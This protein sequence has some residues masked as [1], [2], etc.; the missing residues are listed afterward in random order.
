M[1]KPIACSGVV[2]PFELHSHLGHPSLPLLKKLYLQFSSL[3][4]LNCELCQ[5]AKLHR[6]HLSP[7][8]YKRAST[9][10]ELVH[11]EV[12][13]PCPFL[14]LVGFKYFVTFV[15][16]FSCITCLYLMKSCSEFFSL[17]SAFCAEIQTQ[18]H[19]LCANIEK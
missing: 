9:P 13:S 6:V 3:T 1:P 16:D 17:L 8:V 19:C 15:D 14:S 18:F 11:Y 2:S 12:W 10:F 7:K 4:S 5:Y